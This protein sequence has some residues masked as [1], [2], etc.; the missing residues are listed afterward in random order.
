MF[1]DTFLNRKGSVIADFTVMTT[2][3]NNVEIAKAKEDI[4]STLGEKY[5]ISKCLI[6][7]VFGGFGG[8]S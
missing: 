8:P 5:K 4:V 7:L 6:R 1:A 2:I 3:V